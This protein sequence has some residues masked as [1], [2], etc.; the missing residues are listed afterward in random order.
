MKAVMRLN[1]EIDICKYVQTQRASEFIAK[2]ILSKHQR[3]LVQSFR[4]YQLDDMMAEEEDIKLQE[5]A[6]QRLEDKEQDVGMAMSLGIKQE[7]PLTKERNKNF[8]DEL[9]T[10]EQSILLHQIR[11]KFNPVE[12]DADRYI[13]YEVTGYQEGN[14]SEDFW[15][16]YMD[17]FDLGEDAN[18]IR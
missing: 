2:L 11:E 1:D 13:L 6:D 3:A 18:L 12:I 8:S 9:L 10:A 15:T 4:K 5:Y 7:A 14:A 17:F 16:Q